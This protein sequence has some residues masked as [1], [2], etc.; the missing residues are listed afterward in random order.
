VFIYSQQSHRRPVRLAPR[1]LLFHLHSSLRVPSSSHASP[2][3]LVFSPRLPLSK[4]TTALVAPNTLQS[5]RSFVSSPP[6]SAEAALAM[7][8]FDDSF[9]VTMD[10]DA[11]S[12]EKAKR[13]APKKASTSKA[14]TTAGG[15][16]K[17]A[18]APKKPAA[19]K[20]SDKVN[21][22]PAK[23]RAKKAKVVEEPE[24]IDVDSTFDM[25]R[26]FSVLET[27]Q[28]PQEVP[29]PPRPAVLQEANA[30]G[31]SKNATETYQKVFLVYV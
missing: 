14:A 18:T 21:K 27:P 28:E 8:D 13:Q 7:D 3:Q 26:S 11:Y 31:V 17:K 23:P 30:G 22:P 24:P 5:L 12:P 6:S 1:F 9:E 2:C 15:D 4:P 20:S 25:D 16:K 29:S 19:A 10:S